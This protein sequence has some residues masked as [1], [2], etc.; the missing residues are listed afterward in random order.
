MHNLGE[1][2]WLLIDL[3]VIVGIAL[4]VLWVV[5]TFLPQ[6][7]EPAKIVVGIIVVIA[8]LIMVARFFGVAGAAPLVISSIGGIPIAA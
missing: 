2:L 7:A 8:L 1:L 6:V 5:N 4:L 3:I